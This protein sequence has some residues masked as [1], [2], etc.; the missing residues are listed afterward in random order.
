[1]RLRMLHC[2]M[3]MPACHQ[4]RSHPQ[5]Q[6]QTKTPSLAC[7]LHRI[8]PVTRLV[9]DRRTQ[10]GACHLTLL[11]TTTEM[12]HADAAQA[13]P[14]ALSRDPAGL[15]QTKGCKLALWRRSWKHRKPGSGSKM[16]PL[17]H[18]RLRQDKQQAENAC[19]HL[20]SGLPRSDIGLEHH[21]SGV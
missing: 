17:Q 1:M 7:N 12:T 2:H 4:A 14:R 20:H 15:L 11:R 16:Q 13:P 19:A 8:R 5:S 21:A 6:Q 18:C 3:Q 9:T 10:A